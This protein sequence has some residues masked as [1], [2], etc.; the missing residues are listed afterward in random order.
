MDAKSLVHYVFV[1]G[2]YS[3]VVVTNIVVYY[4]AFHLAC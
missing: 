4:S 3:G 1:Y 2:D